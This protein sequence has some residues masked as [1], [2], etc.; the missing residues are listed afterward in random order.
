MLLSI[1][2]P[3]LNRYPYLI[4]VINDLLLQSFKEFEIIVVDQTDRDQAQVVSFEGLDIKYYWSEIKSA[5]SAR[6]SGIAMAKGEVILFLDDDVIIDQKDFLYAHMKHYENLTCVGVSGAILNR[7]EKFRSNQHY[8]SRHLKF[9]WLFFPINFDKQT[10]IFNGWAGNLSVKAELAR[11]IGGMD[12]RFEKGAFREESDF[13]YRLCCKY[14]AMVYDPAAYIVHI[15]AETGGLRDF[16]A[17]DNIR[18]QHHFDGMF[19]FLFKNISIY[20]YP[21]HLVSFLKIFY[22][23]KVIQKHPVLIF[24]LLKRT[25]RGIYNGVVMCMKGPVYIEK[26]T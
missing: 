9:G 25:F 2:I 26:K 14:G 15:G 12:Q 7:G 3:T 23:R 19:Y 6:N 20:H 17:N 18:G 11:S 16:S 10:K 24:E 1:I 4:D 21:F 22:K 5:S 8:L 13:C